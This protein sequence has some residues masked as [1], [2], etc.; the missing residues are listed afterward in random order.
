[1][2]C[3]IK[4]LMENLHA[5]YD[6]QN[7]TVVWVGAGVGQIAPYLIMARKVFAVESDASVL[8]TFT[9]NIEKLD[10]THLFETVH[11]DFF[12]FTKFAQAVLFDFSLH[13]MIQPYNALLYG[14][15]M[16]PDVVIF[17]HWP[18][19]EW[20]YLAVEE[21]K[22]RRSWAAIKGF[23]VKQIQSFMAE[24]RFADYDEL[25][26]KLLPQGEVSLARIEKYRG[27]TQITVPM[28]YGIA[29]L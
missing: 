10:L 17:D 4:K 8:A 12:Q 29:V 7:K 6:F 21:D 26:Q 9:A 16:A 13:E 27:Q 18:E 24:Q 19:S 15:Q 20:A 2:A 28:A 5:A 23:P 25:R 1:M 22:V 3:D 14:R 11:C